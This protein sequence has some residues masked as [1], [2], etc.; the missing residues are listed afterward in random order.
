MITIWVARDVTSFCT[1][2]VPSDTDLSDEALVELALDADNQEE[3]DGRL[4]GSSESKELCVLAVR[5]EQGRDLREEEL[6][7]SP[8]FVKG[9]HAARDFLRGRQSLADM[10]NSAA[11]A[12]LIDQ[13]AWIAR[14]GYLETPDG[15]TIEVPI[16]VRRGATQAELELALIQALAQK[17]TI[18]FSGEE[19]VHG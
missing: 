14:K 15:E 2:T 17:C 9:G 18:G 19:A 13:P 5:D 16:S 4:M 12:K 7:V 1:V 8:S 10:V 11:D 6:A 3:F